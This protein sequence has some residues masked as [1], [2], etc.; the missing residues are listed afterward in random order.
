[1][2]NKAKKENSNSTK[3]YFKEAKSWADD[4]FHRLEQSR[5][6]YQ[7]AFALSMVVSLSLA[8]STVVLANM[9]T[10]VPLMVHHYENGVTTIEPLNNHN[11]PIDKTQVESDI[12]RYITNREAYDISSYRAQFD[13]IGLLSNDG[14][15]NEYASLQ[16]KNNKDSPINL[17]KQ[18]LSREVH[19]YSVNFIDATSFNEKDIK[20]NH[21]N[22]AEVVFSLKDKDRDGKNLKVEHFNALISWR[23]L[24]PPKS[25]AERWQNWDGF[26]V[27]RYSKQQRNV[28]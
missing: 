5:N 18:D 8:I 16:D 19:V 4:N 21:Q 25:P 15:F 17:L 22:L 9:Q 12:V 6:R 24:S 10:L 1:M 11:A 23:Y 20:K 26:Q 13:L 3:D 2:S 27:V 28:R 14:V 7:A